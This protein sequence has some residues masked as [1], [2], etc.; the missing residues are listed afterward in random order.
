MFNHTQFPRPGPR[1]AALAAAGIVAGLIAARPASAVPITGAFFDDPRCDVVPN[2]GLSHELGEFTIFPNNEAFLYSQQLTPNVI[3]VPQ[4]GNPNDW[5][6]RMTNVSGIPWIDLHF[7][8]DVGATVGNADGVVA[9]LTNAA[10]TTDAFRIDGT[11]T[12][13]M[14]AN[15]ISESMVPDEIFMPGEVWEFMV[16]NF[17]A[18]TTFGPPV[19]ITPGIFA[20]TSVM[21]NTPGNASILANPIPEPS[22]L[23]AVCLGAALP[24]R[25][26]RR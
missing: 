7:V 11:V 4:D 15:L 20:G 8:C 18:G 21:P 9:D 12:P 16:S 24:L 14:N 13:G 1:P 2:T 6:I 23:A 26:K 25:R 22:A 5:I 19:F 3:C 17:N 10:I